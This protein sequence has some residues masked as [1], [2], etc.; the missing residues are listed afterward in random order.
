MHDILGKTLS[1]KGVM[2]SDG[3]EVGTLH[4]ITMDMQTGNLNELVVQ[5]VDNSVERRKHEQRYGTDD[6][7]RL[8]ISVSRVQAVRDYIIVE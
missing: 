4:N 5:P 3:A 8:R 7:N 1:D 2:D 6:R